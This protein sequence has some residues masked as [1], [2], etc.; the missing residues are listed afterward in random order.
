MLEAD[1]VRPT[2]WNGSFC[3]FFQKEALFLWLLLSAAH[4]PR[5][6]HWA[7]LG[8]VQGGAFRLAELEQHAEAAAG[9]APFD[10]V[11]L[12]ADHAAGATFEAAVGGDFDLASRASDGT[13]CGLTRI[14]GLPGSTT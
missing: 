11:A 2:L 10:V 12:G 5:T 9:V 3:F 7:W 4:E 6:E 13:S 1:C 8:W 14:C